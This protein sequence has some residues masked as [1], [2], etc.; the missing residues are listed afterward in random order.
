MIEWTL[1]DLAFWAVGGG[2]VLV[3]LFSWIS[4]WSNGNAER[5]SMRRRMVCRTCLN[6]FEDGGAARVVE[7]P[8]CGGL[9][10]RGRSRTLG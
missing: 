4:R 1:K 3:A 7:C 5:R 8:H 10:E 6:V 2:M 9:V